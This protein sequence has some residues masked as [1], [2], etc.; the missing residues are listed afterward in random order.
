MA[1]RK[2]LSILLSLVILVSACIPTFAA[3][4]VL[5]H[6]NK[7][8]KSNLYVSS[9]SGFTAVDRNAVFFSKEAKSLQ[10]R[11]DRYYKNE[12]IGLYLEE[13]ASK[14]AFKPR[15]GVNAV[16]MVYFPDSN[17][18]QTLIRSR[19]DANGFWIYEMPA[20]VVAPIHLVIADDRLMSGAKA[21]AMEEGPHSF[22]PESSGSG[23]GGGRTGVEIP[24]SSV[25]PV[26]PT[27]NSFDL[28]VSNQNILVGTDED[29]LIFYL[30][31]DIAA[32]GAA[33]Y[34]QSEKVAELYDDGDFY[35][36][37][38]DMAGDGIYSAK[39]VNTATNDVDLPFVARHGDRES[40]TV[41]VHVFA[42]LTDAIL[43]TMSEVDDAVGDVL[44]SPA[45]AAGS[46]GQKKQLVETQLNQLATAD[47]IEADSIAYTSEDGLFSFQYEGGI[48][49]GVMIKEFEEEINAPGQ[50][51][52]QPQET[53]FHAQPFAAETVETA[54]ETADATDPEQTEREK[55]WAERASLGYSG[56]Q[57]TE[58]L[59]NTMDVQE[60]G[61]AVVLNA[62]PAFE[63][64]SGN[65]AFRTV[66]YE[67]LEAEWD[68]K[69]LT[70]TL[71]TDVTLEDFTSFG[72]YDVVVVA[73]HGSTYTWNDGFLWLN[74]NKRPAICLVDK[75]TKEK[76]GKYSVELKS[77]QIIKVNMTGHGA[78]YWIL[79]EF[80]E[81]SYSSSGLDGS[82]VF[83]QPCETMGK[84]GSVDY[85]M[86]NAYTSRS[87]E[88]VIGFHNSVY[89]IYGREFMKTYVNKLVEGT[90]TEVAFEAAK[91]AHGENHKKWYESQVGTYDPSNPVA[92]PILTGSKTATLFTTDL[93]N[94]N[95][96]QVSYTYPTYW[97]RNGDVR[98]IT[99][100]GELKPNGDVRMGIITTG[101]GAKSTASFT[102]GTEG[103]IISQRFV[104]P[105]NASTIG[106]DY[107]FV[108]E[109]P[110]EF[111]GSIFN[112]AFVVQM[113]QGGEVAYEQTH[114]SINTST[115]I[116]VTGINF[117]GGDE[118][119]Y[120]TGWKHA[121]FDVTAYRGKMITL[122]FIIYDVGD[123]IYDS[124]CLLDNVVVQ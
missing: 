81:N 14:I 109:E 54:E 100:L 4:A 101:I 56:L 1:K 21:K 2:I 92:Y 32:A 18:Y 57:P 120:H 59:L 22:S 90:T 115:W 113:T 30:A 72:G 7:I 45:F 11:F 36:H 114:E 118:T 50:L 106:F 86:A 124:A 26:P 40:N 95:F 82:F 77:K 112:D 94:G 55:L 48:L 13:A 104:I 79:P 117:S 19:V 97:D 43:E 42:A 69:G 28:S 68:G 31:T 33:L 64:D 67:N 63:S 89:S 6:P 44:E 85:T 24:A 110:M 96:E 83:S 25:P 62:F 93:R 111:V 105:A 35:S 49:G 87:A 119:V 73:T 84:N 88:T 12:L 116:S 99:Q 38:D 17:T 123:S 29:E 103:S 122:S 3:D 47:K 37:G 108:S 52:Y 34:L 98:S 70:T 60:V 5:P 53:D 10:A 8:L 16:A 107:N 75:S 51:V 80:I 9:G 74:K 20:K 61:T 78:C 121:A 15:D 46:E 102:N 65:I 66:F 91:E 41:E 27:P 23:G 39:Y 76:D 58:L 71:D